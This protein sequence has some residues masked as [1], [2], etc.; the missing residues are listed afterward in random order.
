MTC[1]KYCRFGDIDATRITILLFKVFI[2]QLVFWKFGYGNLS[3]RC[4]ELAFFFV[5]HFILVLC[6]DPCTPIL[7]YVILSS[8]KQR[9]YVIVNDMHSLLLR[10]KKR[11]VEESFLS[12]LVG[13]LV[14]CGFVVCAHKIWIFEESCNSFAKLTVPPLVCS[15]CFVFGSSAWLWVILFVC[16]KKHVMERQCNFGTSTHCKYLLS[17]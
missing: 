13:I 3:S 6:L 17:F 4:L 5:G 9:F 14:L 2:Q 8:L 16:C 10:F 11:L 12:D 15:G 7:R 1:R